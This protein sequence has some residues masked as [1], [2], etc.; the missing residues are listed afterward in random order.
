[1][2]TS[3]S[4]SGVVSAAYPEAPLA[5]AYEDKE[6]VEN[7]PKQISRQGYFA[8]VVARLA[9]QPA[10]G[11]AQRRARTARRGCQLDVR[12]GCSE[13]HRRGISCPQRLALC[14]SGAYGRV[15]ALRLWRQHSFGMGE[16]HSRHKGAEPHAAAHARPH[17][18]LRVART[19]QHA[20]R[21]RA[22]Q[23]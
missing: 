4:H 13:C 1:M 22:Q 6:P 20:Q 9:R 12:V 10:S 7:T 3:A 8:L 5:E 21:R 23:A 17:T 19:R 16:K 18:A 15:C 11:R 14:G 2:L